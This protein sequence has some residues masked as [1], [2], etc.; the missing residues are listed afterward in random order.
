MV[1]V[2]QVLGV[3]GVCSATNLLDDGHLVLAAESDREL[4]WLTIAMWKKERYYICSFY[5]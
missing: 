5:Q 1:N 4:M 2:R 3:L